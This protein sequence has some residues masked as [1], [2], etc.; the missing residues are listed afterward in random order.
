MAVICVPPYD[1]WK[2]AGWAYRLVLGRVL[3]RID[4]H[5]GATATQ[6]RYTIEQARAL[7]GLNLDLLLEDDRDQ[8]LRLAAHLHQVA[9][10][11]QP[12][13]R[14]QPEQRDGELAEDLAELERQLLE[15]Q[16]LGYVHIMRMQWGAAGKLPQFKI[17]GRAYPH[18]A[19]VRAVIEEAVHELSARHIPAELESQ[20]ISSHQHGPSLPSWQEFRQ[21]PAWQQNGPPPR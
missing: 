6:D 16:E 15:F 8:A 5:G 2:L 1:R 13:L 17:D 11:L 21:R 10:E 3:T 18:G 7:A 20:P 9:I 4:T 12:E 19:A 14:G